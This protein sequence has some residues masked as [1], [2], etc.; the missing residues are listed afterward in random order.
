M[1][2]KKF[3]LIFQ[4]VFPPRFLSFSSWFV[5]WANLKL[6]GSRRGLIM[7]GEGRLMMG[8]GEKGSEEAEGG[9]GYGILRWGVGKEHEETDRM[10]SERRRME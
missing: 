2:T 9:G 4:L 7:E 1:R 5:P 10:S 6:G 8:K 3:C